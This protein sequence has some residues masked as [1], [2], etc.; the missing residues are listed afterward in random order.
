MSPAYPLCEYRYLLVHRRGHI[1]YYVVEFR[2][3][4]MKQLFIHKPD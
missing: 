3:S 4:N 2:Q 1:V